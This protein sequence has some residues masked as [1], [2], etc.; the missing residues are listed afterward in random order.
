MSDVFS[1]YEKSGSSFLLG[2]TPDTEVPFIANKFTS[3]AGT[4]KLI[5]PQERGKWFVWARGGDLGIV[6]G[7]LG[8]ATPGS[9]KCCCGS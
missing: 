9:N 7:L 2:S 3:P 6:D 4:D 8:G 5:Q 1:A